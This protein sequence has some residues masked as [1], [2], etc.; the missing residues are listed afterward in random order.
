MTEASNLISI[1]EFSSLTR[2]SVRM[3]RHYDAHGVLVPADVDPRTGYRRYSPH[4]LRD[5]ADIRNLRDVGFGVSAISA[6]LAARGTPAWLTALELQRDSLVDESW[7]AQARLALITRLIQGESSM[8][9]TLDRRVVPSMTI[10]ALRDIIP[11]YADEH[12]LWHRMMPEVTRQQIA[13]IGP[14]GVI[15]H[16]DEFTEHDVDEEVFLPI[17]PGTTAV[18]P[19]AIHELP[20]R[21]CLVARV[22]GPYEQISQAYDRMG[23]RLAAEGLSLLHDGTLAARA[24]NLYLNTP[25]E[26][27][28][29]ELVTEAYM[30]LA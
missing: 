12:L 18:A 4:Q 24:F 21:E 20:E 7:A 5:A 19:L 9:I 13:P 14:R 17:A 23:E 16:H 15:E 1:G 3:L 26:V 11:T 30:P 25:D 29:E 10:V 28:A 6:L 8:S 2:L 22:V 27:P